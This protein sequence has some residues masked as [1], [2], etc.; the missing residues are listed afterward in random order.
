VLASALKYKFCE[1][2]MASVI[3]L[4]CSCDLRVTEETEMGLKYIFSKSAILIFSS[5]FSL[6]ILIE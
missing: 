5:L 1:S 6:L 4:A 3:G 2:F